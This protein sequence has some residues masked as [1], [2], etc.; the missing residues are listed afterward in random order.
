MFAIC[1][2]A[3]AKNVLYF[4]SIV[5]PATN[6]GTVDVV[7]EVRRAYWIEFYPRNRWIIDDRV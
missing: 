5:L 3:A 4:M 7:K 6:G 1:L 2:H